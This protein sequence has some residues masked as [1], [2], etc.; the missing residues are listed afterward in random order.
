MRPPVLAGGHL[1]RPA[2]VILISGA[3]GVGKTNV[4]YRLAQHFGMGLT[5]VDDLNLV[6]KHATTP[7]QFPIMHLLRQQPGRW[8]T[9]S[10]DEKLAHIR[11]YA[12]ELSPSISVVIAN[13]LESGA[14]LVL[15]GDFI[16]PSLIALPSHLG[17][18][19]AGRVRGVVIVESS[20]DQITANHTSREGTTQ[21]ARSHA[22][23]RYSAWLRDDAT[24]HGVPVVEARPWDTVL[25]RVIAALR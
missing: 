5:E 7:E 16:L 8:A 21:P 25:E 17:F 13:H 11:A 1:P 12:A 19:A 24:Q 14:P 18:A 23:W 10:D 2:D 4:S 22:S 20:L 6:L 15:E 9:M 3:S